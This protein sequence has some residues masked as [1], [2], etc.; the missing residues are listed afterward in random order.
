MKAQTLRDILNDPNYFLLTKGG[1]TVFHP[2]EAEA[3]IKAW[4]KELVSPNEYEDGM[5]GDDKTM[6]RYADSVRDEIRER[7]DAS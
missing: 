3:A 5:D 2:D 1:N 6:T 7:I 4:A